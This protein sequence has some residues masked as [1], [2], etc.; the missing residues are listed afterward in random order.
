[1]PAS[2]QLVWALTAFSFLSTL[3]V[4]L[5]IIAKRK[6]AIPIRTDDYLA[7]A[8]W[9]RYGQFPSFRPGSTSWRCLLAPRQ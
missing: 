4:M 9:V 8:A 2:G 5:R 7:I 1:M 6:H 3:T